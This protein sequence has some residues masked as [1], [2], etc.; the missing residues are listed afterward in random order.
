MNAWRM[1]RRGLGRGLGLGRRTREF[2]RLSRLSR[3][4]PPLAAADQG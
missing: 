3:L 1:R 2:A 4:S